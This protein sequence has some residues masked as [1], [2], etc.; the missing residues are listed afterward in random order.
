MKISIIEIA[1]LNYFQIFMRVG[2]GGGGGGG[3]GH[4]DDDDD[5]DG[6]VT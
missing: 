1:T 6:V 3:D 2:S 5:G 4:V